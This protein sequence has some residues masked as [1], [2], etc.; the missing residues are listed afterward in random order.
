ME[1]GL[2]RRAT[3]VDYC[4]SATPHQHPHNY[5]LILQSSIRQ[6]RISVPVRLSAGEQVFSQ[7]PQSLRCKCRSNTSDV[8]QLKYEN[9][10][11]PNL[12]PTPFIIDILTAWRQSSDHGWSS[13]YNHQQGERFKDHFGSIK[14]KKKK[15]WNLGNVLQCCSYVVGRILAACGAGWPWSVKQGASK[16]RHGRGQR[17]AWHAGS[18]VS[19][20]SYTNRRRP[21]LTG[22]WCELEFHRI[23][24][25]FSKAV[26]VCVCLSDT[27][28]RLHLCSC[29]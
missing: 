20:L 18:A 9:T 5:L 1:E 26:C 17:H 10:P 27:Y 29:V 8:S 21:E 6:Q 7:N 23:V 13:H 25:L 15:S 12:P 4:R 22:H 28:W 14:G 16:W 3:T 11:P 19:T 24:S 2:L